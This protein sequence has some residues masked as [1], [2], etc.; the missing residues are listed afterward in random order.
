MLAGCAQVLS[1]DADSLLHPLNGQV[2]DVRAQRFLDDR[3]LIERLAKADFIL[4]GESHDNPE[5]HRIQRRLLEALVSRGRRP[6]VAFEPLDRE[7]QEAIDAA[8]AK[9]GGSPERIEQAA[10]P[11][12]GWRWSSRYEPLVEAALPLLAMNLSRAEARRVGAEGFDALG[13]GEVGRLAIQPAW[14]DERQKTQYQQIADGHCGRIDDNRAAQLTR[15]QRA[16]DAVMADRLLTAGEGG[17][18]AILGRGHARRDMAVPVYLTLRDGRR[19]VASVGLVEVQLG[20]N[21]PQ[22]HLPEPVAG[23]P[24]PVFDYVWLTPRAAR[25][26]PCAAFGKKAP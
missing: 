19:S 14:N 18:V 21:T 17:V 7:R 13:A 10:G 15:S 16:R 2:W 9:P 6:A 1:Y 26:D 4:L 3:D 24:E 22:A 25:P 8:L 12:A 23:D 11:E 5:H 20:R